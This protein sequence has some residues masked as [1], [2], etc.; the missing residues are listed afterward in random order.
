MNKIK[1]PTIKISIFTLLVAFTFSFNAQ[2]AAAKKIKSRVNT[3]DL[4]VSL[5]NLC[6]YIGTYQTDDEGTKNGCSFLPTLSVSLDYYLTHQFALSPQ[7]GL[8]MPKSG[9]DE[10]IKRM[11]FFA[12][13]NMKYKT[14]YVN[15]L[16]G[17]GFYFTRISGPGG[18]EELNN[19]NS[20]D[21]FPLPKEAVY[22]RNFILNLGVGLDFTQDWS[23]E[24][25]TY[26]FNALKSEDR[27]VSVG[28]TISYHFGE[29]L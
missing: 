14:N 27:A 18:E 22:S 8:T 16:G 28:A 15:L 12:L 13:A 23:G 6:E 7:I 5:G 19:G 10:N 3:S 25:Y 17:V 9:A 29:V 26:V 20:T 21:S 2:A 11:T 24:L 1:Y 4:S